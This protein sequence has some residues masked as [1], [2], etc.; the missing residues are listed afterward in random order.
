MSAT[1]IAVTSVS[2]T[3]ILSKIFP[4][5]PLCD[6]M[7]C[8]GYDRAQEDCYCNVD[9]MV[10]MYE[11]L[12]ST[13]KIKIVQELGKCVVAS[14]HNSWTI[15]IQITSNNLNLS[16]SIKMTNSTHVCDNCFIMVN[17]FHYKL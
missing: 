7:V 8:Q 12:S 13:E 16:I 4:P 1:A 6:A 17:Y 2:T 11:W 9:E 10:E 3:Y 14:D 5:I 15:F